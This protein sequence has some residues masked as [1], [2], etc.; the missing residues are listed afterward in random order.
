MVQ[1]SIKLVKIDVR[2]KVSN[3]RLP[4]TAAMVCNRTAYLISFVVFVDILVL[5]CCCQRLPDG[6]R[7]MIV[8]F[9][10]VRV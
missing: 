1:R 10:L 3:E 5:H 6:D 8:L 9:F 2:T 7:D 4:I